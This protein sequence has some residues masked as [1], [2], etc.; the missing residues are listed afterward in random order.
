M[1]IKI[2]EYKAWQG[3]NVRVQ[4]HNCRKGKWTKNPNWNFHKHLSD[5]DG[6]FSNRVIIYK[7]E[8]TRIVKDLK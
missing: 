2:L 7:R 3:N 1:K 6:V 5:A 8:F 4:S